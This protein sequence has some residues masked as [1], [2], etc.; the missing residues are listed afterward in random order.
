MRSDVSS[1]GNTEA[2]AKIYRGSYD[3]LGYAGVESDFPSLIR[4]K[5]WHKSFHIKHYPTTIRTIRTDG[6]VSR[7]ASTMKIHSSVESIQ[8]QP[9][10]NALQDY[11]D[12]VNEHQPRYKQIQR[13]LVVP[14][15][16]S[17]TLRPVTASPSSIPTSAAPL[18]PSAPRPMFPFSAPIL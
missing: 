9:I 4:V 8:P 12:A 18:S 15:E 17:S 1:P 5:A 2:G 10:S 3:P 16:L 13:S 11:T 7:C 6:K 14:V